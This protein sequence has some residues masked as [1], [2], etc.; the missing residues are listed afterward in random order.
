[1]GVNT[2]ATWKENGYGLLRLLIQQGRLILPRHPG[3]AAAAQQ[4]GV[5]DVG[6]GA[7]ADRG[8]GAARAR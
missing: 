6:F 3:A 2:S 5:L 4:P 7:S 8:P 1:M